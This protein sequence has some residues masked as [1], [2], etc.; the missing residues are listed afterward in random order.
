ME[1]EDGEDKTL[2]TEFRECEKIVEDCDSSVDV[3]NL[4]VP[5]HFL[6]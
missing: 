1:S 6:F 5:L 4:K 3:P 2:E